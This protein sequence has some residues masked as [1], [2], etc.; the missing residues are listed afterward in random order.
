MLAQEIAFIKYSQENTLIET[1]DWYCNDNG[2]VAHGGAT[3]ILFFVPV[4]LFRRGIAAIMGTS[5]FGLFNWNVPCIVDHL[6]Q[7]VWQRYQV[8]HMAF[9]VF[10]YFNGF[11]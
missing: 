9:Y 2:G 1:L 11:L 8:G 5:L 3:W 6:G 7:C 4:L 10:L